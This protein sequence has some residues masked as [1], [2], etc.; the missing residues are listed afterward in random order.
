MSSE[1]DIT[2]TSRGLIERNTIGPVPADER[3]GSALGLVGIWLGVN[4]LPLTVVTGGLA[5]TLFALPFW[6]GVLAIVLG[7]VIGGVLMALHAS[8]GPS[9]GVP[10]M[11][12]ARGQFGSRGAALIVV[13]ATVM[14]MGFY[15]SNLVVGSQ[16]LS[17]VFPSISTN[18]AIGLALVVSMGVMVIGLR[19]IKLLL[20]VSAIV[21]GT[22]VVLALAKIVS[23]GVPASVLQQGGLTATGF[24]SMLA[25]GAVWQIAYAPYVS[26]YSRYL[27]AGVGSR[28]AFWG[29]FAGS[30][31]SGVLMMAFG[32]LLGALSSTGD[33]ILGI[34]ET[35]GS[36]ATTI[37]MAF[38]L[39]SMLGNAG[40]VYCATLTTLTLVENVRPG[41]IPRARGR[42]VTSFAL[43]LL[44]AAVALVATDNF[45]A[46]F[47][48]FITILLYVL[49]PW[50]A[51][52]LID[53]FLIR[54]GSYDVASFFERDGG[55]YGQWN[56]VALAVY[57][58]GLAVQ[59]PFAVLPQYVGPVAT[60]LHGVDLAWVV[61]LVVSGGLYYAVAARG[62]DTSTL[63][64]AHRPFDEL[65]AN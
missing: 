49:I 62:R 61:G 18:A 29:T 50:S 16:S 41:W 47:T 40:N 9:L 22:L 64:G 4:M 17:S 14:F 57:A 13:V 24:F 42:L 19:L 65:A 58:V 35:T 30:L 11:L 38:A 39:S 43:L 59:V 25:V 46:D 5:T 6:W 53:Y 52:N 60:S 55:R 20:T 56:I 34:D 51:I 2:A 12:Q 45:L 37:L 15:I 7:N 21:I 8:Q 10:Q 26:D 54:H 36:L 31:L 27:P 44:G 33:P 63:S 1:R 28:S 23:D 48:S 32:A 3:N